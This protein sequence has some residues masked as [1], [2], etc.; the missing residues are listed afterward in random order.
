MYVQIYD[1][2]C[3]TEIEG[4]LL[5]NFAWTILKDYNRGNYI[6]ES[7]L[8]QQR[9]INRNQATLQ[10]LANIANS[11]D[12]KYKRCDNINYRESTTYE[13]LVRVVIG[14]IDNENNLHPDDSCTGTCDSPIFK[15]TKSYDCYDNSCIK[16]RCHGR[17]FDCQELNGAD[18]YDICES[19]D[20]TRNYHYFKLFG[21]E[22]YGNYKS[23]SLLEKESWIRG[24]V[25]CD[26]CFCLCDEDGS[27]SHRYFSL[28]EVNANSNQ[29]FVV[30]GLRLIKVHQI[31]HLQIQEGRLM[32]GG[33][34]DQETIQWRPVNAF[35]LT[36]GG[37]QE[38]IDYHR[39]RTNGN[40]A[41]D[42]ED[43]I[44]QYG[45]IVTGMRFAKPSNTK[46]LH[47]K[48]R[49]HKIEP[50]TGV[51][52]SN[53]Q[54]IYNNQRNIELKIDDGV[55]TNF[56]SP[57]YERSRGNNYIKFTHS[58]IKDDAA[59]S[60]IPYFDAQEIYTSPG[61][62]LSGVGL[63]YKSSS[64]SGGFITPQI[65]VFNYNYYFRKLIESANE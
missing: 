65:H 5:F 54:W 11:T 24:F 17:I 2:V 19:S 60:T 12:T 13:R 34:I 35:K 14:Y 10:A 7:E 46:H 3:I 48:L 44:G 52:D 45:Y 59:Q 20:Y 4:Y 36:D 64:G 15:D 42:L 39:L 16:P 6:V 38:G 27:D 30:T 62:P 28:R 29:N 8:M 43:V 63:F 57:M 25:R 26:Y 40:M 51:L 58:S 9:F 1:A 53:A 47:L 50:I 32:P 41:I 61:V 49:T 31:I 21:K 22:I 55:P 37:V 23:C 33:K 18:S 56:K